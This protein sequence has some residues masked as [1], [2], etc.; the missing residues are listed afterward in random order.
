MSPSRFIAWSRVLYGVL[1]L[2][3]GGP[4]IASA[5]SDP[6]TD[7]RFAPAAE[8]ARI[9]GDKVFKR[10]LINGSLPKRPSQSDASNTA[11][12]ASAAKRPAPVKADKPAAPPATPRRLAEPTD[13]GRNASTAT[14]TAA[15]EAAPHT[16]TA[17]PDVAPAAPLPPQMPSAS[18]ATLSAPQEQTEQQDQPLIL[19]HQVEPQFPVAIVRRQRKGWV[20]VRFEVQV[21][22]SVKHAEAVKSSNPRLNAAAV[23]AVAQWRFQPLPRAQSG[24]AELAFDLDESPTE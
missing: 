8:R 5:Q 17:A 3:A 12:P 7:P 11:A 10:I 19:E 1:L 14:S 2:H 20:H 6:S 18:A 9:E 23:E 21:D 13:A 15:S 16:K 4:Q 22:G 24:L